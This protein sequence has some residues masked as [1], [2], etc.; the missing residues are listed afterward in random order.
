MAML[1]SLRYLR[2]ESKFGQGF[3]RQILKHCTPM[4]FLTSL[5]SGPVNTTF[6]KILSCSIDSS[7]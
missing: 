1:I 3:L 6:F 7:Y 4:F 2:L 5:S